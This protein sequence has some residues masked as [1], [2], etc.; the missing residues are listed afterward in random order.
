MW[1]MQQGLIGQRLYESVVN[2]VAAAH[3]WNS[4]EVYSRFMAVR[5]A[6]EPD[7]TGTC[8]YEKTQG[9]FSACTPQE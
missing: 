5:T 1:G 7:C 9:W 6:S 3:L 2:G 4:A 8:K